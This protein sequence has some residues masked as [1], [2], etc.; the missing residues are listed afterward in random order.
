MAKQNKLV[1]K[2][3]TPKGLSL[4]RD[5]SELERVKEKPNHSKTEVEIID[6]KSGKSI[7][8]F[9]LNIAKL[10]FG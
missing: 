9:R 5:I 3:I 8:K 6:F 4:C 7:G 2:V 1:F 10:K